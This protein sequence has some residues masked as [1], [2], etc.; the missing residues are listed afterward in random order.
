MRHFVKN[1]AKF[2]LNMLLG[3]LAA[4]VFNTW[5]HDITEAATGG[6]L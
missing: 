5:G 1:Y 2:W 3:T 6:V 4:L